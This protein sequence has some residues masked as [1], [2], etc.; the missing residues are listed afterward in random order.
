MFNF[1]KHKLGKV[2]KDGFQYCINCG[3]AFREPPCTNHKWI[4][5]EQYRITNRNYYY[6]EV[7]K[8]IIYVNKCTICGKIDRVEID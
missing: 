5:I 1:C 4:L 6:Q 2:E 3:K 7:V 8:S